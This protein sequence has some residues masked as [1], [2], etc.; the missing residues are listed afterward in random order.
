MHARGSSVACVNFHFYAIADSSEDGLELLAQV[1][2]AGLARGIGM[3]L[4]EDDVHRP[5]PRPS[6]MQRVQFVHR[7]DGF[8]RN[9]AD[10]LAM[11][12]Q[13]G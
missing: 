9:G 7:F 2:I 11:N 3:A 4:F 12:R 1:G 6:G 8:E 13:R 5:L 10:M